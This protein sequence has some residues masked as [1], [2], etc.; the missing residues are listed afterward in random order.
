MID[1][2]LREMEGNED[3]SVIGDAESSDEEHNRTNF[4]LLLG[5]HKSDS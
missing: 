5:L 2:L 3:P 1:K 4:D